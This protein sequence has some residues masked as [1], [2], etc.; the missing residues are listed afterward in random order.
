MNS[1]DTICCLDK[2]KN[3]SQF[4]KNNVCSIQIVVFMLLCK[5]LIYRGVSMD[6]V[7]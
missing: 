2:I 5:V 7:F 6:D 1:N 4:Q 3:S